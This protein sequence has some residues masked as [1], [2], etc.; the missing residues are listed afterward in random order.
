MRNL[1]IP[2]RALARAHL[3]T[4]LEVRMRDG[5]QL[6]FPATDAQLNA[7]IALYDA[8]DATRGVPDDLFKGAD[9]EAA[10]RTSIHDGYNLTQKNGRLASIRT[11]LMHGIERCPLCGISAPRTLDHHLPKGNYQPLAIYVRNLVPVCGECNQSK[12]VAAP[13]NPAE[14]FIH[15]YLDILPATRFLR[16]QVSIQ[17]G[18]LLTEFGID[19]TA[20]LPALLAARLD[21]QVRR[22]HLND[23]YARE[24]NTYITSHTTALHMCFDEDGADSV[25][26]YLVRQATVEVS[27]FHANDWRPI[28]LLALAD[29]PDFCNG[30]FKVVLPQVTLPPL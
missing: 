4:A 8:Y 23:R 26:T 18:G 10:L 13:A 5:R 2:T 22:L 20:Q 12:S 7:V 6:G 25:R 19:T 11:S 14:Q 17:N 30:E 9:L 29:H 1:P 24:I 27:R 21:S 15:P 28:L 3:A 16:V